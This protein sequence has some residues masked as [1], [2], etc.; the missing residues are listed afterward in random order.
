MGLSLW[1]HHVIRKFARRWIIGLINDEGLWRARAKVQEIVE[2]ER[3]LTENINNKRKKAR[4][5][6]NSQPNYWRES[7][8]SASRL[9]EAQSPTSPIRQITKLLPENTTTIT[10]KE[11]VSVGNSVSDVE[12]LS[13]E[14]GWGS[15]YDLPI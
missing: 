6:N 2:Q 10:D 3:L 8:S 7:H 5:L 14:A 12:L 9:T 15:D 4:F 13:T 11:I 1:Q